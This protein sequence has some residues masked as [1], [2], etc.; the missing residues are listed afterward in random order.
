MKSCDLPILAH[1]ACLHQ[2][3]PCIDRLGVALLVDTADALEPI[4][5]VVLVI[6]SVLNADAVDIVA[7]E[8]RLRLHELIDVTGLELY[9]HGAAR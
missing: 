6:C 8:G 9:F 2:R 5:H 3:R 7:V 4:G 1:H